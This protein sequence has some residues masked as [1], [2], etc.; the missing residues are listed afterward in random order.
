MVTDRTPVLD[1]H[2]TRHDQ[3]VHVVHQFL[4]DNRE[5]FP[6]KIIIGMSDV[7]REL[8]HVVLEDLGLCCHIEGFSNPGCLVVY[9][10]NWWD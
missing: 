4:H 5:N 2:G 9:T 7:M 8:V 3:V 6:C 1:L 10:I